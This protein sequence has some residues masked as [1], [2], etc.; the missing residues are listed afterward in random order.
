MLRLRKVMAALGSIGCALMLSACSK[1]LDCASDETEQLIGDIAKQNDT[2][3]GFINYENGFVKAEIE[4]KLVDIRTE[5]ENEKLQQLTCAAT[6]RVSLFVTRHKEGPLGPIGGFITVVGRGN[7]NIP[8][9][10]RT[11]VTTVDRIIVYK[12]QRTSDGRLRVTVGGLMW[13]SFQ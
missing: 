7:I 2:V 13:P 6:L 3:H 8:L 10:E 9:N 1:S 12:L 5:I 4:Y 11:F